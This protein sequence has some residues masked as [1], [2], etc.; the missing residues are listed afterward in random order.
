M[1]KGNWRRVEPVDFLHFIQGVTYQQD[2]R[3]MLKKD[4]EET[5]GVRI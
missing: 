1:I 5:T 2:F 4:K 3:N